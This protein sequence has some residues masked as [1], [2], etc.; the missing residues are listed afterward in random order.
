MNDILVRRLG[1]GDLTVARET[2]AMM[3]DVFEE[4]VVGRERLSDD[5]LD[6]L[7][8]QSSFWALAAFVGSE[9][10]GGLTAHT[11]PMTR[12][13]SSE[14][15]IY[16]LAVRRENQRQGVGHRLIRELCDRAVAVGIR[17]VFVPADNEDSHALDFYRAQ[18]AVES[19]VTHFT[20]TTP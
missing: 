8:R 12:S 20:F 6:R 18:G 19:L 9:I 17:D 13:A 5:Y 2:F 15:L 11:L 7:L 16:D 4:D 14:L 1:H 10:V 3:V